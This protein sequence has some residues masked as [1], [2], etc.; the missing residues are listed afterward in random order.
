LQ[1]RAKRTLLHDIG[2]ATVIIVVLLVVVVIWANVMTV[3]R[4][5]DNAMGANT[6][7]PVISS[8]QPAQTAETPDGSAQVEPCSVGLPDRQGRWTDASGRQW[9][10]SEGYCLPL[11]AGGPTADAR[12]VQVIP[13]GNPQDPPLMV[14]FHDVDEPC[15][16]HHQA[17]PGDTLEGPYP[18]P[19]GPFDRNDRLVDA[20]GTTWVKEAT[21]GQC[22]IERSTLVR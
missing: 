9:F 1:P 12:S 2:A 21:S 22:L 14:R 17:C 19:N 10:R 8:A 5:T 13:P 3:H 11:P 7:R 15:D 4:N 16:P 18:C 6:A 20:N